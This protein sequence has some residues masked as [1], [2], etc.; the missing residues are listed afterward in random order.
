MSALVTRSRKKIVIV[1]GGNGPY[2]VGSGLRDYDVDITIICTP[3][4]NGGSSGRIRDEFGKTLPQGDLRR[5][6]M[7]LMDTEDVMDRAYFDHRFEGEGGAIDELTDHSLGNIML[8][9]AHKRFGPIQGTAYVGKLFGVRGTVLPM[10][11]DDTHLQAKL[12]DGTHIQGETT[13]DTRPIEDSRTIESVWLEPKAFICRQAADAIRQADAVIMGPG[14]LFTS[15]V[16]NLCVVGA[17]ETLEESKAMFICIVN[18]MDKWS[19]TRGYTAYDFV[20]QLVQYGIGR[21]KFD[22]AIVNSAPIPQKV[23]DSYLEQEKL[24]PIELGEDGCGE[25]KRLRSI[26]TMIHAVDLL[27]E[28]GL[29]KGLIRHDSRKVAHAI[30]ELLHVGPSGEYTFMGE[31]S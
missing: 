12:S 28:A 1:G 26:V 25:L 21:E 30:M 2:L 4:D 24:K 10:S 11:T 6:I 20:A 17:R 16:P 5:G 27:S 8:L 29:P 31:K 3:A 9:A 19:E 15:L 13:I 23:L 18:Q 7:A 22:A 14:D